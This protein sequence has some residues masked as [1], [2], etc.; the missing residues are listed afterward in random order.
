[1]KK[2]PKKEAADTA[3]D[4]RMIPV[5]LID[6]NPWNGHRAAD[7][8]LVASVTEHGIL[9]NLVV[10]P[11]DDRF[12]IVS[13]TRRMW[14]AKL[15]ELKEVPCL[16]RE[17]DDRAAR[18][19]TIIENLQRENL[20]PVDEAKAIAALISDGH[21]K[22]EVAARIGK[23]PAFV[24]RRVKLANLSEKIIEDAGD[25]LRRMSIRAL[26]LLATL[27]EAKQI[28]I[29]DGW[30]GVNMDAADL[31]RQIENESHTIAGAPFD[32]ADE[33][34]VPE[35]GT[36]ANCPKRTGAEPMLFDDLGKIGEG[37]RCLDQSCYLRK[38]DAA[39]ARLEA[40]AREKHGDKLMLVAAGS[41]PYGE[42]GAALRK[43]GVKELA[44]N[45][46]DTGLKRCKKSEKGATPAFIVH[47]KG[48][49]STTWVRHVSKVKTPDPDDSTP[50][51]PANAMEAKREKLDQR[52]HAWIAGELTTAVRESE[53]PAKSYCEDCAMCHLAASFGGF[54]HEGDGI[55]YWGQGKYSNDAN[56]DWKRIWRGAETALTRAIAVYQVGAINADFIAR[57]KVVAD[58]VGVKWDDLWDRACTEIPEPKSWAKGGA[59]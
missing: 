2:N 14:A 10:R 5:D 49:G 28:D 18:E 46:Q 54:A 37:D 33:T 47:G 26:E 15:A 11:V 6:P 39:M 42:D 38:L 58:L 4:R 59:A 29:F 48:E 56:D 23:T 3:G 9:Q 25:D 24:T 55:D 7:D 19:I 31:A 17:L 12:Q 43:R 41:I 36:C 20:H 35:A 8:D 30:G 40:T 21:T 27:P 53:L 22:E 32:C 51:A 45:W 34:L 50:A 52:R 57:C 1:M 16:V 13:G 44:P